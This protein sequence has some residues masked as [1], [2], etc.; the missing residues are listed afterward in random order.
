MINDIFSEGTM[1][2]IHDQFKPEYTPIQMMK[3]GIFGGAYFAK[4]DPEDFKDMDANIVKM[5]K[6]QI[7]PFDVDKNHFKVK[8]G[9]S[10]AVW[11]KSGWVFDEDPLGW[12]HCYCRYHSGR[13]HMRDER[14]IKRWLSYDARWTT[15][16]DN[17]KL[18]K[19]GP[20]AK[21]GLLQWS[22][23]FD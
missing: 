4:A 11:R 19:L 23:G 1:P 13:R 16:K 10:L 17:D 18:P 22:C 5:A 7:G 9:L 12:F 21:Q 6:T 3:M 15:R 8:S 14:Q 20:V 2:N